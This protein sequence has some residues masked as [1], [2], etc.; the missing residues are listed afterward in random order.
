MLAAELGVIRK[1]YHGGSFEIRQCSCIL[2]NVDFLELH[3]RQLEFE[4]KFILP[5]DDTVASCFDAGL[6][7]CSWICFVTTSKCMLM[8]FTGQE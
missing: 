5:V 6:F 2:S 3:C 1:E 8:I 4:Q 7:N